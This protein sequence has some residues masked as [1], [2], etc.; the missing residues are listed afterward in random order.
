MKLRVGVIYGSRTC[1]HDVSIVS[2]LQAAASLN[3][4]EYDVTLIYISSDGSWYIGDPLANIA[5][6]KAFDP[7]RVTKV[8]PVGDNGKLVLRSARKKFFGSEIEATV[9]V[10]LTVM[11]GLNGE[12]GTLQGMLELFNVPYTSGGV[13]GSAVGMDKIMMKQVFRANDLPVVDAVWFTREEWTRY[14]EEKLDECEAKL[15]YPMYVKP[16]NLGSSIGISRAGSRNELEDAIETACAYDR[17]ILVEK[18]ITGLKEVNCAAL[19]WDGDITISEI[20]MPLP[21]DE[22]LDFSQKYLGGGGS[23]GSK[24]TKNGMQSQSRRIPAP[25]PEETAARVREMTEKAFRVLD[26]KGVVRVDFIIAPDGTLYINE[27]NTIPGSLSFYLYE[28]MGIPYSKLLDRMIEA[29]F[30]ANADKNSCVFSF[31]S[32]ILNSVISGGTKGKQAK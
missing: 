10:C 5:F 22:F 28:P 30:K 24:S 1:E 20:E 6:Y 14:R 21:V 32:T 9:D 26:L 25:I 13:L 18:G 15:G 11:H 23:K 19:G 12:D 7:Y 3:R 16:S 27:A 4:N 8:V 31:D 29:A 17:R 2:A